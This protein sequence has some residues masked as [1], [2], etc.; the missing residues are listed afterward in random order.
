MLVV[1]LSRFAS[2][3]AVRGNVLV[4]AKLR[5]NIR[6]PFCSCRTLFAV[7][8]ISRFVLTF[9]IWDLNILFSVISLSLPTKQVILLMEISYF[10]HENKLFGQAL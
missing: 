7:G 3:G 5:R 10:A 6:F 2:G 4:V 8:N 1:V 9:A